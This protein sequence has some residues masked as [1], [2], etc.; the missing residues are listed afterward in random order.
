MRQC[1]QIREFV[2]RGGG[3]VATYET[4]LYDEW[5]ERRPDFGLAD[6]FGAS[7]DGSLD[8]RMQNSYLRLETDPHTGKR[9]PILAGLE[10]A[11]RII[12]G[13]SRVHTR[14]LRRWPSRR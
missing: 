6:L 4:S 2:A 10:D 7:F 1:R 9:H 8:E 3:I 13:V 14:A 5:G 11:E 12:N